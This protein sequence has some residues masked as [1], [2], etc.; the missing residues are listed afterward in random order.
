MT[1]PIKHVGLVGLGIMGRP[2]AANLLKAGFG[3][4]V[5]T[6]TTAKIKELEA[7]G[8]HGASSPADVAA[9][10]EMIVTMVPDSPDVEQV[11]EGP[12]GVF[13]GAKRGAIV[14]DMS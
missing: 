11:A 8:A 4:T 12:G 2:M 10:S 6:R 13:E 1:D 14:A 5:H 9:R 7:L 3:V